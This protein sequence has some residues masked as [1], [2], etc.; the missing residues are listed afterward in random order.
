MRIGRAMGLLAAAG[1]LAICPATLAN[2]VAETTVVIIDPTDADSMAVGHHY[3]RARNIP[4]SHVIY[5]HHGP[6][7][8][9]NF[10]VYLDAVFGELARR[11]VETSIDCVVLAPTQRFFVPATGLVTDGCSPVT[12]FSLPTCYT[13]AFIRG[14][15]IPGPVSSQTANQYF[16]SSYVPTAF[17]S[18]TRYL[19]GNVSTLGTSRRYLIAGLLGYTG[20]QGNTV[21]EL[22]TMIDR[23]VAADGTLPA[24][25]F[26]FMNTTDTARNVRSTQYSAV[27][28]TI[29]SSFGGTAQTVNGVLPQNATNVMGVMTGIAAFDWPSSNSV[30]LPGAFADHLTSYAATFDIFDQTKVSAWIR[31][32]ASGSFGAVEE[33]CNYPGKFPHARFHAFYR[34][35]L[36]I[37]E[38][39]Y[40]AAQFVPF[41]GL[42]YGDPLTRPYSR[43]PNLSVPNAPTGPVSGSFALTPTAQATAP[44]AQIA[45]LQLLIDGVPVSEMP[46]PANFVIDTRQLSDGWH[47][48]RIL[49][50][51][52][53]A[54]RHTRGW[55]TTV[56]VVNREL[57][58]GITPPAVTTATL[59]DT[60][61]FGVTGAGPEVREVRLLANGRVVAATPAPS[62]SLTVYGR[63][64]GP[65]VIKMQAEAIFRG[66][67]SAISDP[68]EVTIDGEGTP[69]FPVQ[70]QA[71]SYLKRMRR[72]RGAV[73]EL[74]AVFPDPYV[75]VQY[76]IVSP[77]AHSTAT[78]S[79][80]S[81]LVS[82]PSGAMMN[83][84]FQ[85]TV[86]SP[87][88]TTA[89]QTVTLWFECDADFNGDGAAT[90]SDIFEFLAA[91]FAGSV[92]ADF[93][94]SG[95][96]PAV[97]DIFA[98]LS[99]WFAGC[100]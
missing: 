86:T 31:A 48:V 25:Q 35:G 41:Q 64:L 11:G 93:D 68:V 71:Y 92:Y 6:T 3:V 98:Y 54:A 20:G 78:V 75:S 38:S 21:P 7:T 39:W 2:G 18:Q 27:V 95:G 29:N 89:P 82:P 100:P 94:N 63:N 91:W 72:D 17:D 23:S 87:F 32:G 8:F 65:G 69:P 59:N 85:Y 12:R 55:S 96:P 77:P 50:W 51:D 57:L 19:N 34:Q 74:P 43:L 46:P 84:S 15:I 1:M 58:A 61:T 16:A 26:Y 40:R 9:Q 90:V 73:A 24:G 13:T 66:N 60:L 97:S 88:G 49:A 33:P 81:V 10:G 99:A 47:D 30:F 36:T 37:G 62:A 70:P 67:R 42:L 80:S 14:D 22:L 5:L 28:T 79:G 83:D 45:A 56:F 53:S 4:H 44:N 52:T 76:T